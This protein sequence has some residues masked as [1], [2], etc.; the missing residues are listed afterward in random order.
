MKVTQEIKLSK[1]LTVG[2]PPGESEIQKLRKRGFKTIINLSKQKE[3]DQELTPEAEGELVSDTG[4]TYIHLP[5]N[6]TNVKFDVV[7]EFNGLMKDCEKPVYVHCCFGQRAAPFSVIYHS[8]KRSLTPT[9]AIER[10][11][12]L[13]FRWDAPFLLDFVKRYIKTRAE[14]TEVAASA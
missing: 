14:E 11:R 8:V 12:K 1:D 2:P 5:V 7:D 4:M 13:G 6:L 3:F 9:Q 10:S